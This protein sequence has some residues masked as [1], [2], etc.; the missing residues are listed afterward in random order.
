M[1]VLKVHPADNLLVALE[2]LPSGAVIP[3][4]SQTYTLPQRVAAK[5]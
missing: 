4:D 2:D 3:Y 1:N 5:H